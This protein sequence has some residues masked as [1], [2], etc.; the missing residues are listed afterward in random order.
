LDR[1][2]GQ[3]IKAG[4]AVRDDCARWGEDAHRLAHGCPLF[5]EQSLCVTIPRLGR[6]VKAA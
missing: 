6:T 5:D 4:E 1:Q 2:A 3:R